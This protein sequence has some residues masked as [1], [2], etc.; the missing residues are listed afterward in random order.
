MGAADSVAGWIGALA[1]GLVFQLWSITIRDDPSRWSYYSPYFSR[2]NPCGAECGESFLRLLPLVGKS[3]PVRPLDAATIYGAEIVPFDIRTRGRWRIKPEGWIQ[4]Q[5]PCW[6]LLDSVIGLRTPGNLLKSLWQ[7]NERSGRSYN[8]Y[9]NITIRFS[10]VFISVSPDIALLLAMTLRVEG[11]HSAG[12]DAQSPIIIPR[13]LWR[14]EEY[15]VNIDCSQGTSLF[16]WQP[17]QSERRDER[18]YRLL[19]ATTDV[20]QYNR[21]AIRL[22]IS[23]LMIWRDQKEHYINIG[24]DEDATPKAGSDKEQVSPWWGFSTEQTRYSYAAEWLN[25]IGVESYNVPTLWRVVP[26]LQKRTTEPESNAFLRTGKYR[27]PH[28]D[29]GEQ[30]GFSLMLECVAEIM[31]DGRPLVVADSLKDQLDLFNKELKERQVWVYGMVSPIF[32]TS[33]RSPFIFRSDLIRM[34]P[35]ERIEYQC[36][37]DRLE[38]LATDD[39]QGSSLGNAILGQFVKEIN[40][41]RDHALAVR[42][43]FQN[44]LKRQHTPQLSWRDALA[45]SMTQLWIK[46]AWTSDLHRWRG[47]LGSEVLIG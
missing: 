6:G 12:I 7:P 17:V 15:E 2:F 35:R 25:V 8:A 42:E 34:D 13:Y 41:D 47:Q 26:E 10:K 30:A 29:E 14:G 39:P 44:M 23:V 37:I 27:N 33:T 36:W 21:N 11:Q 4:G 28:Q 9:G 5:D 38:T 22:A 40:P 18:L 16:H 3:Q 43:A 31:P 19:R 32:L 1:G 45:F 46:W 24:T 20:I